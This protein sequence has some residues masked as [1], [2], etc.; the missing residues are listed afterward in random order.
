MTPDERSTS[1]NIVRLPAEFEPGPEPEPPARPSRL[2]GTFVAGM[3]LS[4]LAGIASLFA[5]IT[6][7]WPA[8]IGRYVIG[9]FFLCGIVFLTCASAAVFSAARDTYP[10][11]GGKDLD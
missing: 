8:E 3:A 2:H 4:A 10:T 1:E 9:L 11:R 6:V 7:T 5:F